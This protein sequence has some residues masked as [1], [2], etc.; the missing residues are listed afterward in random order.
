MG[1]KVDQGSYCSKLG[2]V[3]LI[4]TAVNIIVHCGIQKITIKIDYEAA[5][6]QAGRDWPLN[7]HQECF[8]Y[9]QDIRNHIKLLP[10]KVNIKWVKKTQERQEDLMASEKWFLQS[11]SKRVSEGLYL[12][13]P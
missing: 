2:G 10:I 9:L 13:T 11:K 1:S 3:N 12:W 8:D 6:D 5:V 7:V 4:L